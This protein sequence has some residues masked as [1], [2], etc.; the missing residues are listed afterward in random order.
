MDYE[1]PSLGHVAAPGI[2][3]QLL[4]AV[5]GNTPGKAKTLGTTITKEKGWLQ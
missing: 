5:G 3:D 2:R 1:S 4:L